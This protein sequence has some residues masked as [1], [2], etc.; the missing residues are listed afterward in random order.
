MIEL[1][2]LGLW[3]YYLIMKLYRRKSCDTFGE[4]EAD[5]TA[6]FAQI[7]AIYDKYFKRFNAKNAI[8]YNIDNLPLPDKVRNYL[9]DESISFYMVNKNKPYFFDNDFAKRFEPTEEFE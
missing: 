4:A 2:N 5:E 9:K 6:V 3:G 8:I 1:D 7:K